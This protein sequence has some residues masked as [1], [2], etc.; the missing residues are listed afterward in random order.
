MSKR[1]KPPALGQASFNCPHCH[2]LAHQL[3]YT[4]HA[5]STN[6]PSSE[7]KPYELI[8][9]LHGLSKSDLILK[10][11]DISIDK[12]D[13]N[14]IE[15]LFASKCTSCHGVS[16]W[17]FR[18]IAYPSA[19]DEI[20]PE[21]DMPAS[22]KGDFVEASLIVK[23]SPRGAAALLRLC[24]QKLCIDLGESD[25]I[26]QAIGNLVKKG[27]PERM[28]K[29]L[30]IVRVYGNESVHPGQ[31]DMSDDRATA[32]NLFDIVNIIV[33]TVITDNAK[34]DNLYSNMPVEKRQAIARR[35]G[36]KE[37]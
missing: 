37:K 19:A 2:A 3:W 34:I 21:D 17:V 35:D 16:I 15:G 28:Q 32:M 1:E 36:K 29:M 5:A 7:I 26:D 20:I 10:I 27:M 4:M 24:V 25:T 30:D 23:N 11:S 18:N 8:S 13:K 6:S 14:L 9:V 31:I 12:I 33:R 22:I